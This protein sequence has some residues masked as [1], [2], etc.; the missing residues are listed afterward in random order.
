[1]PDELIAQQFEESRKFFALP[2]EEKMRVEVRT[3]LSRPICNS[4]PSALA[5]KM[6][7]AG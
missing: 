1:M 3:Y 6:A 5:D 4:V 2:F 7:Y